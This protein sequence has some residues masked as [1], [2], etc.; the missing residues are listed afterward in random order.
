MPAEK[1]NGD[2][3]NHCIQDA[4]QYFEQNSTLLKKEKNQAS[5]D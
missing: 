5:C 1:L 4:V 3:F 2:G